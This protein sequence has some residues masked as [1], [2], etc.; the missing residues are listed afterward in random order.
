MR[1]QMKQKLLALGDDYIIRD[2][3]GQERFFVDGR[4]LALG[5]KLSFE[6]LD[7][8]ELAF[9]RQ[10][11]LALGR[12][13]DIERQGRVT[14]IHKDLFTLFSCRFTIDVPG[15]NDLEARGNL[16]DHEYRFLDTRENVVATVSKAWVSVRDTY[17]VEI[18]AG[19]DDVLIL[20]AAVVIDL[21][22]HGD[23]R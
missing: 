5:D 18:A 7:G 23:R 9:I 19:Q 16:T 20:A 21:C 17:G 4:A 8:N 2:E 15:P 11:L 10:R 14:T 12:T 13:Y 1:Y 6:D 22:C 3:T